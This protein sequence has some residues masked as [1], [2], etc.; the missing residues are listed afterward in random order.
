L[1][2]E[3][4]NQR[5]Y[6]CNNRVKVRQSKKNMDEVGVLQKTLVANLP[7]SKYVLDYTEDILYPDAGPGKPT[8]AI[9]MELIVPINT[10]FLRNYHIYYYMNH[11]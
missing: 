10:T 9:N 5:V 11:L 1:F 2:K 7:V 8:V 4:L 6:S 3:P